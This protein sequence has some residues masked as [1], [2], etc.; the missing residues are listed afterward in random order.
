MSE[1][2]QMTYKDKRINSKYFSVFYKQTKI[3]K[4]NYSWPDRTCIH[5]VTIIGK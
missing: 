3:V 1:P 5:I 2:I 4:L